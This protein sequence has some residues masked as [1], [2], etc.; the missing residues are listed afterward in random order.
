LVFLVLFIPSY[1]SAQCPSSNYEPNDELA[2][3]WD[4]SQGS[5]GYCESYN[6]GYC[7]TTWGF[8]T[9]TVND[10]DSDHYMLSVLQGSKIVVDIITFEESSN[11][12]WTIRNSSQI[13]DSGSGPISKN[14]TTETDT[15][16]YISFSLLSGESQFY[17]FNIS[18]ITWC[19]E[20]DQYEPNDRSSDAWFVENGSDGYSEI[21][22]SSALKNRTWAYWTTVLTQTQDMGEEDWFSVWV[23]KHFYV[24]FNITSFEPSS[25]SQWNIFN[26]SGRIVTGWD[27]QVN[28][29]Q[30]EQEGWYNISF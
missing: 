29:F 1:A 27:A 23:P 15:I 30:A 2:S 13:L 4:I 14:Y 3:A 8:W 22:G 26:S 20:N 21:G 24:L 16:Y 19:C 25:N 5:D 6:D 11:G 10:T 12:V 17:A 28:Q 18:L 9:V 7:T